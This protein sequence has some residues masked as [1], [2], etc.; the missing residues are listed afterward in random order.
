MSTL[1]ASRPF[2]RAVNLGENLHTLCRAKQMT[3]EDDACAHVRVGHALWCVVN[4][5]SVDMVA[6][7]LMWFHVALRATQI[8]A[9]C[10][11]WPFDAQHVLRTYVRFMEMIV[12]PFAAR[13][14]PMTFVWLV[15]EDVKTIDDSHDIEWEYERYDRHGLEA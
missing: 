11:T 12:S 15:A 3:G 14:L 8:M 1:G 4:A 2:V 6:E 10:P 13:H 7:A 5:W 9:N